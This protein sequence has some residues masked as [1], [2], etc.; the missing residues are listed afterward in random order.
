MFGRLGP[1]GE[2]RRGAES[3][4]G[5]DLTLKDGTLYQFPDERE[6]ER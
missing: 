6:V 2:G 4:V 1:C 5:W 3:H